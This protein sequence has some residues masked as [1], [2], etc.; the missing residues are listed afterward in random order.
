MMVDENKLTQ[1]KKRQKLLKIWKEGK[2]DSGRKLK[3]AKPN[4]RNWK[5]REK[6][7]NARYDKIKITG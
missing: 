2:R 1:K 5:M 7:K 4:R 6:S 3:N